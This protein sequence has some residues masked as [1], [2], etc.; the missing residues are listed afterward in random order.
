[1]PVYH[2]R[3]SLRRQCMNILEVHSP[4]HRGGSPIH[5]GGIRLRCVLSQCNAYRT[6]H[7]FQVINRKN[8]GPAWTSVFDIE[9]YCNISITAFE[10][11]I[12]CKS[13]PASKFGNA[14]FRST[15]QYV[16]VWN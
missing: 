1:M 4:I 12:S 13:Q 10:F 5:R 7:L 8:A 11:V 15:H 2:T 16:G 6:G 14:H 3:S 9:H